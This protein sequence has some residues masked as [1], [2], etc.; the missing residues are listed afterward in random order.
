MNTDEKVN[1]PVKKSVV[2]EILGSLL[3]KDFYTALAKTLVNAAARAFFEALGAAFTNFGRKKFEQVESAPYQ[4]PVSERVWG[5]QNATYGGRPY[6]PAQYP[7]TTPNPPTEQ[8]NPTF[9]GFR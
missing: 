5:N 2:Q 3:T 8:G 4:P 6:Q 7:V 1:L 9:P